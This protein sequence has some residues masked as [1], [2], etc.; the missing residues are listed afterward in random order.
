MKTTCN[1]CKTEYVLADAPDCPVE[2]A[3]CGHTWTVP[4]PVRKNSLLVFIAS[5]CALLSAA[6]FAFVVVARYQVNNVKENPLLAKITD[7]S[8]VVDAFGVQHFVV[9]GFVTNRSTEIYGVPDLLIVSRDANGDI[10]A[11]QKFMPSATLL[12]AGDSVA[13]SH[14]L[15]AATK[16]VKK[17][18]AELKE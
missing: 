16:G 12:D 4:K 14:T 11:Q 9:G 2:C 1:F 3:V 17:L 13:F 7:I 6:I 8:T 18:T 5:V 10:V 15:S